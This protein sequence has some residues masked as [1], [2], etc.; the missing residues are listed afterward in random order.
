MPCLFGAG[1][2]LAA[3]FLWHID[4]PQTIA[5]WHR[6]DGGTIALALGLTALSY[7]GLAAYDVIA[8]GTLEQLNISRVA[9]AVTG[10]TAFGI[11]N[12]L[13]FPLVTGT[14]VRVRMYAVARHNLG[15]LL[16]VV[17]SG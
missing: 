6:L 11:S 12:F 1:I 4:W 5:A 13:G 9:A 16:S 10:A 14:A 7:C 3:W 8:V 2:L 15:P 17:G